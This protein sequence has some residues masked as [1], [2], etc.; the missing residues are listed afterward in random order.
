V[1]PNGMSAV[2]NSSAVGALLRQ[3]V[4]GL[5]PVIAAG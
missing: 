1:M 2:V 5:E 4:V 3:H